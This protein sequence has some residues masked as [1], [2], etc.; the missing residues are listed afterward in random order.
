MTFYI[1]LLNIMKTII[2]FFLDLKSD[3][4][5]RDILL[6]FVNFN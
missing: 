2:S 3:N 5:T 1:K 6:M 4:L